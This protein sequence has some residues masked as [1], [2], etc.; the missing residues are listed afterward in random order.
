MEIVAKPQI[1]RML[2]N[3]QA[4]EFIYEQALSGTT[5][6]YEFKHALTQ[7]VAYNSLL[8]ER[9]KMLHGRVGAAIESVYGA[10]LDDHVGE[11][12]RHY[13][14][15]ENADKAVEYLSRAG[16]Q[17]IER[18]AFVE[19]QAHLQ[20][21]LERIAVL[22]ESEGRD[23]QEL[24][25]AS[26]LVQVLVVTRGYSAPATVEMVARASALAEKAGDL[27]QLALQ[28]FGMWFGAHVG[29]DFLRCAALA[30]RLLE[31]AQRDGSRK[32]LAFA[33]DAELQIRFFRGD[34]A[35]AEEHFSQ[36]G[37][38]LDAPGF[39]HYACQFVAAMGVATVLAY[40][41]GRPDTARQRLA[42]VITFTD[43]SQNSSDAAFGLFFQSWLYAA[44]RDPQGAEAAATQGLALAEETG[45]PYVSGLARVQ[46]GW[47]RAR[48]GDAGEGVALIREGLDGL[49][50]IGSRV[51]ITQILAE[52]AE[53]QALSGKIDDALG[54]I[55]EALQANHEERF[56]RAN[57]L[58]FRGELRLRQRQPKLAEADFRE[59]IMRAQKIGAK[60][61][62]L[63]ATTSL[64]KLLRD[65]G[66][67]DEAHSMLADIY[68][69]FTEGFD[70]ADLQ[71]AKALLDELGA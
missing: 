43:N 56:Y 42:R 41:T 14:S 21:G 61:Y 9:R 31:L 66:R 36:M 11:L 54:S 57:I 4:G 40:V 70:T 5:V 69:W 67:R 34:L 15:S 19:A 2:G 18:F 27:A 20:R 3:L 12:A 32:S 71:E 29:G 23:A 1:E 8:I 47:A 30:D 51:G 28:L 10:Q 17:A 50:Q 26:A 65:T 62:E 6:A 37:S 7:E 55:E 68:N 64:A 22:P 52:L 35:G 16:N 49:K 63:L 58:T 45:F 13:S 38:L 48:L 44:L 24:E 59:A 53:A 60:A 39:A 46:L 33:H 25:L